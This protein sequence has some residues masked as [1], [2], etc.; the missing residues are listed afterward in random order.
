VRDEDA[1]DLVQE[2]MQIVHARLQA[3]ELT[4]GVLVW[5]LAVLRN[6]IGNYY[7][8]RARRAGEEPFEEGRH[9]SGGSPL[10]EMLEAEMKEQVLVAV[11]VLAERHPRCGLLFRRILESLSLGGSPGEVT[12]RALGKLRDDLQGLSSGALYVALHR[13]RG[14]LR[15]ILTELEAGGAP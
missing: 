3:G 4:D 15:T 9:A 8:R 12:R 2:A 14:R 11:E 6:R 7:Q 10:A 5:S 13:C 1:E